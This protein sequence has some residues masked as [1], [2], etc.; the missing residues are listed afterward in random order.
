MS[1]QN[2]ISA[3]DNL[4]SAVNSH[5]IPN[6]EYLLQGSVIDA[7]AA[8]L[9]HRLRGLCDA[10]ES[11]PETFHDHEM[12]FSL[13]SRGQVPVGTPIQQQPFMLRVRRALDH[14]DY[15][16][17][18]RYLGNPEL[19][20]KSQPTV[21]RS[22]IDIGCCSSN[23]LEFLGEMGFRLEFEF[24]LKGYLFRKGRMKVTMSKLFRLPS[25]QVKS[26]ENLEAMTSSYLVELSLL[27]PSGQDAV[28]DEIKV[29]ADQLRPLVHLEKIDYR[30]HAK[31]D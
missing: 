19:G 31:D 30:R 25:A 2:P 29:F 16:W 17:Q 27:A 23:V 4:T 10:A 15:P 26:T 6:Q 11:G 3:I 20:E 9:L 5:I 24:V 1:N 22:C 21:L 14:P 18:L 8:V 13:N 12:C 7:S 28:A